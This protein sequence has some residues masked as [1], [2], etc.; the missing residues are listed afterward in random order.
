MRH[1]LAAGQHSILLNW[2]KKDEDVTLER[3]LDAFRLRDKLCME[4][5]E[6]AAVKFACALKN[7]IDFLDVEVVTSAASP[8]NSAII[9]WISCGIF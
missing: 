8:V 5:V 7:L 4:V 6:E 9:I 2:A 1:R 3:I